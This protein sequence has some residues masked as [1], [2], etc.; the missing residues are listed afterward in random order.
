MNNPYI[1]ERRKAETA[2]VIRLIAENMIRIHKLDDTV[3][4]YL[5]KCMT[6]GQLNEKGKG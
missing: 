5:G 2:K 6:K 3:D 1:T 4:E